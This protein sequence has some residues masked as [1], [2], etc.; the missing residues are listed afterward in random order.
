M[1]RHGSLLALLVGALLASCA[2]SP[3][4][5]SAQSSRDEGTIEIFEMHTDPSVD[6]RT[7][8]SR[9]HVRNGS[10]RGPAQ[11]PNGRVSNWLD[12]SAPG[13]WTGS[14]WKAPRKVSDPRFKDPCMSLVEG[15]WQRVPVEVHVDGTRVT[16]PDTDL[17]ISRTG[18]GFRIQGT[19][20]GSPRDVEVTGEVIVSRGACTSVWTRIEPGLYQL[21]RRPQIR[22]RLEGAA[23]DPVTAPLPETA[24]AVLLGGP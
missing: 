4:T 2:T 19:W 21:G 5:G 17:Q 1:T 8:F 18:S 16:G 15:S 14:V 22:A 9:D 24:F 20:L 11:G 23:A 6:T 3:G 10:I 12:R 7:S 13:T